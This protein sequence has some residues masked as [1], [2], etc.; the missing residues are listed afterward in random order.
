MSGWVR[1]NVS[2][3][4]CACRKKRLTRQ[5]VESRK[6]VSFANEAKV[7]RFGLLEKKIK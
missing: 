5:K 7:N 4:G 3:S 6:K 1:V 2:V